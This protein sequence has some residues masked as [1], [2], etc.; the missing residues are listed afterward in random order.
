MKRGIH[1]CYMPKYP[2]AY[3]ARG[4]ETIKEATICFRSKRT[5]DAIARH[6]GP[7][8]AAAR[9]RRHRLGFA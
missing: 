6:M 1:V 9:S 4:H 7:E 8:Y 2:C 5:H 3:H